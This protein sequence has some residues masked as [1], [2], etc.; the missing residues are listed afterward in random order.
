MDL[1]FV[2]GRNF[3]IW[4]LYLYYSIF[5]CLLVRDIGQE[6]TLM[7]TLLTASLICAF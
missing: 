7:I 1:Q 4:S 6:I 5:T 3:K 2:E